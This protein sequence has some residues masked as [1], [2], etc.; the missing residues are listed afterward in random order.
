[1]AAPSFLQGNVRYK[2]TTGITDVQTII[3]D[4]VAE[5]VAL[6][7]AWTNPSTGKIVSPVDSFGR[8]IEL[9]LTR[10]SATVLEVVM[11]DP[12]ARTLT[13]R[14]NISGTV[15]CDFYIGQWHFCLDWSSG[16]G[17]YA[18]ILDLSPEDGDAHDKWVFVSGPRDGVG[19]LDIMGGVHNLAD[20]FVIRSAGT[21]ARLATGSNIRWIVP[22]VAEGGSGN[23]EGDGGAFQTLGGSVLWSPLIVYGDSATNDFRIRGRMPQILTTG[24][25]HVGA[26]S[27]YPIPVDESTTGTFRVVRPLVPDASYYDHRR[28]AIRRS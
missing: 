7:P 4:A 20:G 8:Y 10:V 28:F 25:Q 19:T 16:E 5:A 1:M 13:R 21:Y 14:A 2:E 3:D 18:C 26:N 6:T 23:T 12:S 22:V 15:T 11:T 17:Y 27:E 9:Q 24:R